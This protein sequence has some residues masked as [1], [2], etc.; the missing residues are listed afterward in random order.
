MLVR[1]AAVHWDV[2]EDE[3]STEN[4]TVKHA[5]SGQTT[6]YGDLAEAAASITP[7]DDATLKSSNEYRLIGTDV[8]RLDLREKIDGTAIYGTDVQ[9]PGMLTATVV[10]PPV[11]GDRARSVRSES[12]LALPG[13]RRVVEMATGVAV[14][15]DTFWQ[16]KKA[17]DVLEVEWDGHGNRTLSSQSIWERWASL[18]ESENAKELQSEGDA[19]LTMDGAAQVL[20]AVY[21]VPFQS[22]AAAEPMSC[23]ALVERNR[24]QVWAPTQNQDGAQ[25]AAARITGL[26]YSEID[27]HTT[28]VGGGFGR[29][30]DLDYVVEAVQLSKVLEAPVKVIWTREEDMRHGFYRPAS[31]HVLR[32]ALD[33]T[34]IPVAWTHRIVGPDPNSR[35]IPDMLPSIVP[36]WVPRG[37]RGTA[38]WLGKKALPRLMYGEGIAAGAVP[39]PYSIDNIRIDCIVDDPGVPVGFWRAVGN[40]ANAFP[41]ECFVDEIAA[42]AGR[43]PVELRTHLFANASHHSEVLDLAAREAGWDSSGR[44]GHNQGVAVHEFD[45]TFVAMIADV[46]LGDRG[47][48]R[49]DRVVCGVDCGRV[50][51]P[52]IVKTQIAS[53]I[54]FGLTATLMGEITIEGGSVRESNYH[55][56]PILTMSEMPDVEVHLV[57]TDRHPS[58]IG[59]PG[60]PP[61]APAV[62]N[63]VY[64]ATG[65]RLRQLPLRLG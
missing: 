11:F 51:N 1:A 37:L 62:A 25:E 17:A 58:G 7:P 14:V 50:L 42:A 52:R 60:V 9:L 19:T 59:E 44:T 31:Y 13:V 6:T 12:A 49:V 4:G 35:M 23:A 54:A 39:L 36:Y 29:R 41:L 5:K 34:G 55:N 27:I 16:A 3:C 43:D 26:D 47:R 21:K 2:S 20:E 48:I 45:E 10:H 65:E 40:S 22:H 61:I 32:A 63:A 28:Y 33:D 46:S 18:A 8:P 30:M 15:A 56:F 24:C 64:A 57:E 53:A 38:A